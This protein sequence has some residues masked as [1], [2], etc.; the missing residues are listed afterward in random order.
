MALTEA[1]KTV[2]KQ[3][4]EMYI[5]HDATLFRDNVN[6][7]IRAANIPRDQAFASLRAK[8]DVHTASLHTGEGQ[9]TFPAM[10]VDVEP[11]P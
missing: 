10:T 5:K 8:V 4:I 9:V 6:H 11:R 1:D 3:I 2:V 7:L